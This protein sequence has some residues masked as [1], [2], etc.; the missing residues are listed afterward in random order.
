MEW[1]QTIMKAVHYM[2]NSLTSDINIDDVSNHVFMSSS[3]FQRIFKSVTDITIGDYIRNRRLSLAGQDLFLTDSKVIDIA[4]Q[5]Q[6]NT[7]ES[8]SKAFTRFHGIPPSVA[9]K[10]SDML[11]F[12][13]PFTINVFIQ[14][15]FNMSKE[16]I[17]PTIR[18]EWHSYESTDNGFIAKK[19]KGEVLYF[20]EKFDTKPLS[21]KFESSSNKG[22][23]LHVSIQHLKN[24]KK[25]NHPNNMETREESIIGH[26]VFDLS[27]LENGYYILR[28]AAENAENISF[29]YEFSN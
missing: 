5:Y 26:G 15:G 9:Q 20:F 14:G 13:H 6:Y 4:M 11:K 29:G 28:A 21:V 17:V 10:Q 22:D 16:I 24:G 18:G 19:L 2:E 7:S 3:N 12:F 1:I 27:K 8:F 23:I 25:D